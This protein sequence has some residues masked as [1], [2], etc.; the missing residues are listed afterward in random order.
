M[1]KQYK[2]SGGL[3]LGVLGLITI[4]YTVFSGDSVHETQNLIASFGF[5]LMFK[6]ERISNGL[7]D[8]FNEKS[9][10]ESPKVENTGI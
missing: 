10:H 6:L 7:S 5:V 2:E 1:N 3:W 4:G 8:Y 9:K